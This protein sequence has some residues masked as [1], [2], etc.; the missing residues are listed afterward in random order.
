MRK[1][2]LMILMGWV[3]E[4]NIFMINTKMSTDKRYEQEMIEK[5]KCSAYRSTK[6]E[7][8]LIKKGDKVLL[9]SNGKGIIARGTADGVVNKNEDRGEIN[10]EYYMSL[11]DFYEYIKAIPYEKIRKIFKK[12]NPSF[13]RPFNVT[14]LKFSEPGSLKIWDEVCKYVLEI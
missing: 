4:M 14:S 2:K 3:K 1:L 10:A 13:A 5:Q 8:E 9:Y 11:D 12:V 6:T 7:I